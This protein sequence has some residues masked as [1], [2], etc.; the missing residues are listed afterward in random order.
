MYY[1]VDFTIFLKCLS[2]DLL[3][4]SQIVCPMKL[5]VLLVFLLSI[6]CF[7]EGFAANGCQIGTGSGSRVFINT[8]T[9][10][11]TCP[12]NIESWS[13]GTNYI[14][15]S[16]AATECNSSPYNNVAVQYVKVGQIPSRTTAFGNTSCY[17]TSGT[18]YTLGVAVTYTSIYNC[19]LDNYFLLMAIPLIFIG[20]KSVGKNNLASTVFAR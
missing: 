15:F 6:S 3:S 2:L 16:N 18:G 8:T 7:S 9:Q 11:G 14:V 4:L 5:K 20:F 10:C 17:T 19:P 1:Y 12:N 13:G